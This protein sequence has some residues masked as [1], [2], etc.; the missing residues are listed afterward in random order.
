MPAWNGSC[1]VLP[2]S[3]P[4]RPS[5]HCSICLASSPPCSFP[6]VSPLSTPASLEP[7]PPASSSSSS[8][9]RGHGGGGE[10]GG[11]EG[12]GE[13]G[14]GEGGGDGTGLISGG[15]GEGGGGLGEISPKAY[16]AVP[17]PW[18]SMAPPGSL[19]GSPTDRMKPRSAV[20][21]RKPP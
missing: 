5:V 14:G 17:E 3:T 12:G 1:S 4:L 10:G 21:S 7:P 6:L 20:A 18:A 15:G 2:L 8:F 11:G 13:G 19:H 9:F 16:A